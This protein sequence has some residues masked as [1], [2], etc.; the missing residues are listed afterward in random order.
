MEE[1]GLTLVLFSFHTSNNFMILS[2]IT[3]DYPF[4]GALKLKVEVGNNK[5]ELR[6]LCGS[7]L[8][9]SKH[10]LTAAHCF[11]GKLNPELYYVLF[12]HSYSYVEWNEIEKTEDLYPAQLIVIHEGYVEELEMFLNDIAIIVL[13]KSVK[14]K[15]NIKIAKLTKDFKPKGKFR[16]CM[17]FLDSMCFCVMF[18]R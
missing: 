4:L 6:Q 1:G 8:I 2:T 11:G 18:S 13:T 17:L 3:D 12:G 7:S 10:V 5:Y 15:P 16:H 14:L 9:S